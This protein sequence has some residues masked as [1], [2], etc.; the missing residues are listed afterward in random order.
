MYRSLMTRTVAVA[1]C[2]VG[3]LGF[4]G[5]ASAAYGI[6]VT[7]PGPVSLTNPTVVLD[8]TANIGSQDNVATVD[9]IEV[10]NN[11]PATF[12]LAYAGGTLTFTQLKTNAVPFVGNQNYMTYQWDVNY[13]GPGASGAIMIEYSRTGYTTAGGLSTLSG[14]DSM[15]F[16]AP[17]S[18]GTQQI[19]N[20]YS[21]GNTLWGTGTDLVGVVHTDLVGGSSQNDNL[22]VLLNASTPYTFTSKVTLNFNRPGQFLGNGTISLTP[23][24]PVPAGLVMALTGLPALGL[25]N[26]L[27]RRNAVQA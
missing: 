18:T 4:V 16:S 26:R 8:N 5:N 11:T 21:A 14:S 27:R 12:V 6:R 3:V 2:L 7:T 1:L 24:V 19:T 20:S 13:S 23:A 17:S 25:F 9:I 22:S 15:T 10:T